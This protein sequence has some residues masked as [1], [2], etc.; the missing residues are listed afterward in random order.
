MAIIETVGRIGGT[1][2]S[3]VETRLQLAALD[4]E[5]ESQRLLGYFMLALLSL[6]LFGIA[7]VLVALTII[8]VFWDTY[9]LQAAL[10]LAALFG[11]AGTF[12]MMKLKTAFATRPRML[13]STV[14][15]L[16]K[17]VNFFR[18]AGRDN[19]E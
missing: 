8:L 18:N 14:A 6:I 17:D 7:M 11:A 19:E 12:F 4:I 1:L 10:A 9:R 15:E 5:E 16:N 13:A 3:M 2:L